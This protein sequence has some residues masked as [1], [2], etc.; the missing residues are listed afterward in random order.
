MSYQD[1]VWHRPPLF[2]SCLLLKEQLEVLQ[3]WD[4]PSSRVVT[5]NFGGDQ[6]NLMNA[7]HILHKYHR[8]WIP[9]ANNYPRHALKTI[10]RL[11]DCSARPRPW[12]SMLYGALMYYHISFLALGSS[13]WYL[14]VYRL[15][16]CAWLLAYILTQSWL[17]TKHQLMY[18]ISSSSSSSS[19]SMKLITK[20][21]SE[22]IHSVWPA[23]GIW[24]CQPPTLIE[25]HCSYYYDYM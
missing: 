23:K 6:W 18:R 16:E 8:G 2:T 10:S 12:L 11:Q 17:K 15:A 14:R 24:L 1:V 19:L 25:K 22:N 13:L 20:F 7:E 21:I 9:P 3:V 4:R 5:C